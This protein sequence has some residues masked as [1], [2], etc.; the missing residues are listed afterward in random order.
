MSCGCCCSCFCCCLDFPLRRIFATPPPSPPPPSPPPLHIFCVLLSFSHL[1]LSSLFCAQRPLPRQ[2][3]GERTLAVPSLLKGSGCCCPR[4]RC[5]VLSTATGYCRSSRPFSIS[6]LSC[7]LFPVRGYSVSLVVAQ[8]HLPRQTRG[9]RTLNLPSLLLR[10]GCLCS[11]CCC[12]AFPTA[13]SL[14]RLSGA[15]AE[16]DSSESGEDLTFKT[17]SFI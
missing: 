12:C 2:T 9:E 3:R 17:P 8:G 13:R 1:H 7:F 5:R 15:V 16:A 6:S 10:S 11:C 4:C 14:R